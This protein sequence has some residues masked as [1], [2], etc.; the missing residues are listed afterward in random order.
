MLIAYLRLRSQMSA[1][2]EPMTPMAAN[3]ENASISGTAGELA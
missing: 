2:I 1:A 3:P